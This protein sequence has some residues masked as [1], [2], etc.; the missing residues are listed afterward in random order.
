MSI[1]FSFAAIMTSFNWQFKIQIE[2]RNATI[3]LVPGK[4]LKAVSKQLIGANQTCFLISQNIIISLN[5][6]TWVVS[7]ALCCL[8]YDGIALK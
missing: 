2:L 4:F 3:C 5:N 6:E 7:L 1:G 8:L